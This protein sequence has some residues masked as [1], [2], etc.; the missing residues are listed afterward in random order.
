[1]RSQTAPFEQILSR[2]GLHQAG[3]L[4]WRVPGGGGDGPRDAM[5]PCRGIIDVQIIGLAGSLSAKAR[6]D[7]LEGDKQQQG[8]CN[9]QAP[10]NV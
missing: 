5:R 2:D 8:A 9:A 1:M 4:P 6:G 10:N 3:T 7:M